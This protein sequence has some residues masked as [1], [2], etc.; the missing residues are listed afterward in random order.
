MVASRTSK[1][2]TTYIKHWKTIHK[3]MRIHI[4]YL[5]EKK[6]NLVEERDPMYEEIKISDNKASNY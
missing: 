6:Y 3:T 4:D 2:S 5:S 1:S